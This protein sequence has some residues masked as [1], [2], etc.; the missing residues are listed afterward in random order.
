MVHQ[1]LYGLDDTHF[2]TIRSSLTSQVPLPSLEEV[3]NILR[4]EKDVFNN[5]HIVEDN[6]EITA[7]AAQTRLRYKTEDRERQGPCRHCN[8]GGHSS[9]NFFVVIGYPKW[10]GDRLKGRSNQ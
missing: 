8:R 5:R 2:H 3:Y 4:Q 9:D 1:F 10:W 7:F 6:P